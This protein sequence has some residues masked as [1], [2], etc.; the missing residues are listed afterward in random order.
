VVEILIERDG[1]VSEVKFM[2]PA[3]YFEEAVRKALSTW[4]YEPVRV[5]GKPVRAI[6][7]VTFEFN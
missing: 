2:R 1:S 6:L 3:P 7:H 5:E 4:K